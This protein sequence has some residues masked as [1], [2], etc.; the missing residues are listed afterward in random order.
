MDANAV[1]QLGLSLMKLGRCSEAIT[2]FRSVANLEIGDEEYAD[3]VFRMGQCLVELQ[4]WEDAFVHF[5]ILYDA[6]VEF[7]TNNKNIDLPP[8]MRVLSKDKLGEWLAKV[9]PHVPDADS[10]VAKEQPFAKTVSEDELYAK[11]AAMRLTH[12]PLE[13]RASLM[14]RDSDF[15]WFRYVIPATKVLRDD[16]PTG[17]HD[18]VPINPSDTFPAAQS[19]IFLVF[20]LVSDSYDAVPLSTSCYLERSETTGEQQPAAQ[21]RV[22]MAMSDQSGYF[23]LSRPQGDGCRASTAAASS[24]ESIPPRTTR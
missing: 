3:T 2:V 4:R 6:A 11:I 18:F 22:V 1:H 16:F 15:S 19:E 5:Q 20:G 7:E 17:A 13:T 10:M 23:R 9:K 21:D 24:R 12:K 8:G 14:G